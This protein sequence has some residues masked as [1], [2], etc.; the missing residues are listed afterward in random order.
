MK[1]RIKIDQLE[2]EAYKAMM[3]MEKYLAQTSLAPALAS[4]VKIRASQINGCTYCIE[5]HTKEVLEQGENQNKIVALTAWKKSP[6]FSEK[7]NAALLITEEITHISNGGVNDKTYELVQRYFTDNEVAN[8][9]MLIGTI[10]TWNRIA[11]STH[12]FH[13][14]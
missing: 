9:I 3:V 12:M 1:T 14:D 10:N 6:L 11:I 5:M 8:L 2:P 7:E 13:V 4:L